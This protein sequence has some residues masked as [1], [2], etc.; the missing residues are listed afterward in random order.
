MSQTRAVLYVDFDNVFGGLLKLDPEVAAQF[1]LDPGRWLTNLT[2]ALP[3]SGTRRWLVRRCYMNPAG[4]VLDPR[5]GVTRR[6][7]F[8][9]FRAHLTRAG[10]E[11]I[12][13]PQLTMSKNAADI[14]IVVDAIDSLNARV[15]YDE[16]VIASGDSDMT[17][18]L[19]YLRAAGRT[20]TV[21]STSDAAEGFA[22]VP[23][24]FVNGQQILQLMQEGPAAGELEGIRVGAAQ[25]SESALAESTGADVPEDGFPGWAEM[26][27]IVERTYLSAVDPVNLAALATHL[28]HEVGEPTRNW[29][30]YQTFTNALQRLGLPGMCVSQYY[31]WDEHRHTPPAAPGI[32]LPPA[33]AKLSN[34]LELPRLPRQS[35]TSVYDTLAEYATTH[36][37]NL[38]EATRWARDQLAESGAPVPRSAVGFVAKATA[39]GGCPLYQ[40]PPPS[41]LQ[42]ASATL[43]NL[44]ERAEAAGIDLT[45]AEADQVRN[46]MGVPD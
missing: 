44:L 8:A 1:A 12:D 18:L 3:G 25:E 31:L 41:S 42:I 11:V 28:K 16:Y 14:R 40:D 34:L 4:S 10:Y 22:A 6:F 39:F 33:I 27:A 26:R 46:W 7:R 20:T 32:E 45:P 19:I 13:C 5:P 35:W 21:V 17:P 24:Q 43:A 2:G 15:A 23:D 29:F 9:D 38:T 36:E 37:F 30:G